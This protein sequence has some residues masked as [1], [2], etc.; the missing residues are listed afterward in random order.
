[1]PKWPPP[2]SE[3]DDPDVLAAIARV[4]RHRFVPPEYQDLAYEDHP[5]PIGYGQT[6]SQPFVVALMTQLLELHPEAKVLEVGTGCGYQTAILAELAKEVYTIEVI[7]ELAEG[8]QKRLRELGY[9]NIHFRVGDGWYGWP[10]AAPFDGILVTAAAPTWPPALI[11]QLAE[12][13]TLV[14]PI[15]PSGWD[16]D[17]WQATKL[18][19]NL[20]KRR[21]GPVRFVPLVSAAAGVTREETNRL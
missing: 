9:T 8:A 4:P 20:L 13:G 16:Q 19:G 10:E 3:I 7:P 21:I 18:E 2:W 1:M 12:G 15:G 5:L 11:E 17:L 14:I 6:I